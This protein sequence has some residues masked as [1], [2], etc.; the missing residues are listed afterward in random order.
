VNSNPAILRILSRTWITR[1]SP[2]QAASSHL[3]HNRVGCRVFHLKGLNLNSSTR[4]IR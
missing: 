2:A 1:W 3:H 4:K